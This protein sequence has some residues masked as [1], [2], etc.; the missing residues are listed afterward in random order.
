VGRQAATDLV[1]VLPLRHVLVEDAGKPKIS[2]LQPPARRDEQI[3][4]LEVAVL[5][6]RGSKELLALPA[7][8]MRAAS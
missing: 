7:R 5:H 8:R 3:G 2:N 1:G 4:R 6:S